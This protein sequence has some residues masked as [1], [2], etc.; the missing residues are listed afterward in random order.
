MIEFDKEA[1]ETPPSEQWIEARD[2]IEGDMTK[3]GTATKLWKLEK[4]APKKEVNR[5]GSRWGLI[6]D[7]FHQSTDLNGLE[8]MLNL[9]E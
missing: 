1:W 3:P 9:P 8:E 2:I 4:Q 6:W 7:S 5:K